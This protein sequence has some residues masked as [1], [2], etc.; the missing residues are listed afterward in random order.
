MF[1]IQ[2]ARVYWQ[3]C[4]KQ[5][6]QTLYASTIAVPGDSWQPF[7]H[8]LQTMQTRYAPTTAV[9][10]VSLPATALRHGIYSSETA[11]MAADSA[12]VHD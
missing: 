2:E 1:M 3:C 7:A 11:P 8:L 9:H 6:M 5:T 4:V 12:T 10:G